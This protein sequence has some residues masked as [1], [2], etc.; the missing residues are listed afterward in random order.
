MCK[1]RQKGGV[2]KEQ[3]VVGRSRTE[4]K[5]IFWERKWDEVLVKKWKKEIWARHGQVNQ[6]MEHKKG[7]GVEFQV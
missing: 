1:T 6:S 7:H 4:E 2:I 5:M 3:L